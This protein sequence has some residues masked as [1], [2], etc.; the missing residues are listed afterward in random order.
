MTPGS[1]HKL[2][3]GEG[4]IIRK[5][6][7]KIA[8]YRDEKNHL[9]AF[10]AVCPHLKGILRWNPSEKTWDCPCHGSR[11]TALGKAINGPAIGTLEKVNLEADE[12]KL[13]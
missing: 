1:H 9:H 3:A 7:S 10:S 4:A 2:K 12:K 6:I 5:G 11:F 13:S 8:V